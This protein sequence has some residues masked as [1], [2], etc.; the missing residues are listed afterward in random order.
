MQPKKNVRIGNTDLY[1]LDN[2]VLRDYVTAVY[3]EYNIDDPLANIEGY[4]TTFQKNRSNSNAAIKYTPYHTPK[5]AGHS[6]N[7]SSTR[8]KK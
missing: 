7:N 1:I 5:K 6:K 2:Q 4:G 8:K 3:D